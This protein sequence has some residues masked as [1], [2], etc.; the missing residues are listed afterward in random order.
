MGFEDS[1]SLDLYK[2]GMP[3]QLPDPG[4]R[5]L[6]IRLIIAMLVLASLA[7]IYLQVSSDGTLSYLA[8][9][10]TVTGVVLDE[11]GAPMPAEVFVFR[12]AAATTAGGDGAFELHGVP[13]GDQILVISARNI[14]R[15]YMITVPRGSALDVGTLRFQAQDFLNGWSQ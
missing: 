13:A 11:T 4:R 9:S 3:E 14:G 8:G 12:T 7:L 5:R 10:G 2:E 15:E 1:P 6:F